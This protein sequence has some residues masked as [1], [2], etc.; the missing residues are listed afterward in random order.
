MLI[1]F[2]VENFLSFDERVTL[3]LVAAPEL[4]ATDGLTENTFEGPGGLR[5]VKSALLFGANGSGKSNFVKAMI[6][7][8]RFIVG[9]AK[10]TQAG[11]KIAVKPF[12]F[13]SRG[14]EKGSTFETVWADGER[15]YRY[16][17][18][19]NTTRVISERLSRIHAGDDA[20]LVLFHRDE[21]GIH[22]ADEFAEGNG[23]AART[24]AN[25]LFLSVV[26]QLNGEEAERILTWFREKLFIGSGLH[27]DTLMSI[28][29]ASLRDGSL[30]EEIVRLAREADLGIT[31]LSTSNITAEQLPAGLSKMERQKILSGDHGTIR[32]R[33][34]TFADDGR[35]AGEVDFDINDESQGTQKLIALA[36]PLLMTLRGGV[37]S[38]LDE[39]DARLHPRLTQAIVALFQGDANSNNAQLVVATHDTNLLDRRLVRRDQVWF[40][41]KDRRGAT[42]LYSL[43]EFDDV[44]QRAQY[45]R[46]YLLGKFGAVPSIGA[47]VSPETAE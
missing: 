16:S 44:P 25:A 35:P 41:E 26:A 29:L 10:D 18:S 9:S 6:F 2:S 31:G 27:D 30:T 32:V 7:A 19:A 28:T 11:E 22:V 24:R 13:H 1:E 34:R 40:F 21:A 23:L 46:D 33:H 36:A 17:F 47:L 5:L 8:A 43:A 38:V 20:P 4:D 12:G 37:T 45:E 14:S 15:V 42:K 3:S 39:F